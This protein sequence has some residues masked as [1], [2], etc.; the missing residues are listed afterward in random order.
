MAD[1]TKF[2]ITSPPNSLFQGIS[3][4]Y[5]DNL[6]Y[7]E[8]LLGV[9]KKMNEVITQVNSNTSFIENYDGRI[10]KL[11]EEIDSLRT[12]INDFELE[13]NN[14]FVQLQEQLIN[15]I[16]NRLVEI[17]TELLGLLATYR[18]ESKAYTDIKIS[19]VEQ[20]IEQIL[21][22]QIT[23]RDPTTGLVSPLQTVIDNLY[24]TSRDKAL[25][26]EEY[27]NLQLTA[28]QYDSYDIT[29][30]NYDYNGKEILMA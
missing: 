14:N 16:N 30:F 23:L 2:T 28:T 22:G 5:Q 10:A 4:N 26:A 3:T 20:E 12:E 9:L 7:V 17:R 6:T 11:E 19:Q 21:I 29:A 15:D 1:I 13:V 25:T 8:Y 18:A 27:D 24:D